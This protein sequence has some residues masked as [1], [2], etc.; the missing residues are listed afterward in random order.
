MRWRVPL[1]DLNLL[2]SK[3]DTA[4]KEIETVIVGKTDTVKLA[5]TALL[6][7]GHLLIEDIPGVGKTM[8]A[9]SLARVMGCSFKRIQF[10]PDLLP[11][12][13]TGT[14]IFNQKTAEFEFR[15]G[16]IFANVVLADEV[17]R[18]TPK[19]QSALLECMEEMQVTVDGATHHLP[20][21]FFVVATE[22]N[23]ELQGT[24][25]LPE[26][27]LD[28][29]WMRISMGY[30]K[31]EEEMAIL[32]N[33]E[34][35]HPVLDLKSVFNLEEV[36]EIQRAIRSIY[37]DPKLKEYIVDV[38]SATRKHPRVALGASP[39]GSLCLMHAG[40]A[41]AALEG[42]NYV[43]PDHVKKLAPAV[44]CHRI[45]LQPEARIRDMSAVDVV[46]EILDSVRIPVAA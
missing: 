14:A 3:T 19:T 25:P 39:R 45:I 32:D 24:Y 15:K 11:A 43:L 26:A 21:P 34:T 44:L 4:I 28:R 7:N 33:Q 10:T 8:L 40:K 27:Q 16:P 37:I 41:L 5:L 9:R 13:I 18:A 29:F 30:P 17:N 22:N 23:I 6:C 31:R 2:K 12:D 35:R 20:F 42:R 38:V 1:V 46:A 36:L